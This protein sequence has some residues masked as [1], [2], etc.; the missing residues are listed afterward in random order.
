MRKILLCA[1]VLLG[2]LA[3][4][5]VAADAKKP[6]KI[7]Y[8]NAHTNGAYLVHPN[9]QGMQ[10]AIDEINAK[11][12]VLGRPLELISRDS[13]ADPAEAVRL[14][15]E[16][17]ARDNVDVLIN[18]DFSGASI[19]VGGWAKQ[20]HVPFVVTASEADSIIWQNGNDYMARANPGGYA[21]VSASLQKATEVFGDRLKNKRWVSIAP[22][23]EFGHAVVQSAHDLADARGLNPTW[24]A[25]QWPAYDKLSA[26]PTIATLERANPDIVFAALFGTDIVKFIREARKR[27]FIKDRIFIFPSLGVPEHFDM[28][29][30]ETPKGWV[31]IGFPY[32]EIK[33]KKPALADFMQRYE[34]AYH[35]SVKTYLVTGYDGIKI[36]AAAI[37]KA[38]STDPEKIRV[39]FDDLRFNTPYGEQTL[40]KIDHQATIAYWVGLSDVVDGKPKI[41][42]WTEFNVGDNSPP[43]DVILKLRSGK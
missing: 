23:L 30:A 3:H 43:D 32:D 34:A 27:D 6:I 8:I 24:V 13:K 35:E 4:S 37:E 26:G 20:N 31:T 14:A 2:L 41:S 1:A 39:A 22:S 25:E 29:G 9:S 7:G 18:G 12:G 19:A 16:L 36:L 17:R 42:N 11:G 15:E 38:G 33:Q 28:L 5:A 10:F 21:W 40:R